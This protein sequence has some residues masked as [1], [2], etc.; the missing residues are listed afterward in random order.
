MKA[1]AV[2]DLHGDWKALWA[3]LERFEPSLILSAGDWGDK[4]EVEQSD[5]ERLMERSK[6]LSIYGN[7]DD[8]GL[9]SRLRNSDGK[10]VLLPQGEVIEF[11]A[12]RI[13]GLSGIWAKSHRKPF[14]LTDNDV[15]GIAQRLEGLEVE[16]VLAHSPP[17]GVADLTPRG[18]HGGKKCFLDF[19]KRV[20]PRL[21]ICGH[22]HRQQSYTTS[23]GNTVVNIGNSR[24]GDYAL[25]ELDPEELK[26]EKLGSI[27]DF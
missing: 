17:V 27:D 9:L 1:L 8:I 21:Y 3:M 15:H 6:V 11:E 12:L 4:G 25:I 13:V 19:F 14:Y 5:F 10:A 24:E 26:L 7:H 22:L 23:T 18:Y 2:C 20:S 16:V